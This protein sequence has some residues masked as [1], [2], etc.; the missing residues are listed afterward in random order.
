MIDAS[1]Q[2]YE[3]NV[4]I[5]D[6]VVQLAR[7]SGASVEAEL[8]CVGGGEGNYVEGS[9]ANRDDFTNPDLVPDWARTGV[10]ALAVAIGTVH[11]PTRPARS[12]SGAA[13]EIRR[14]TD[15][16]LVLHGGSGLSDE[17]F[18]N[19]VARDQQGQLLHRVFFGG[20]SRLLG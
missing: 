13:Q 5:T 20:S 2:P 1:Q 8:S 12:R 15:V 17:D 14:K 19:V 10:D 11:G 9:V 7:T 6:S 4:R 18:R 16:P 3:D